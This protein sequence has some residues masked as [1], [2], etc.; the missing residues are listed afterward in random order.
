M[1]WRESRAEGGVG[2]LAEGEVAHSAGISQGPVRCARLPWRL[3]TKESACIT[4]DLQDTQVAWLDRED[5][6]EEEMASHINI[7]AW[8]VPR[9]EEPGRLQSMGSQRLTD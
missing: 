8:E 4:G 6:R 5:P 1:L 9:T 7:L 3:S 2:K